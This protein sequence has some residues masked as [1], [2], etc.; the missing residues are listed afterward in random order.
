MRTVKFLRVIVAT[1]PENVK[2]LLN[3]LG[4]GW[5]EG[6][7]MSLSDYIDVVQQA[8]RENK[9]LLMEYS[10]PKTGK[11]TSGRRVEPYE[12]KDGFLF[13]WDIDANSIKKFYEYGISNLEITEEVFLP[14]FPILIY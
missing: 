4:L 7:I 8:A 2:L 14:R 3:A 5:K 11:Y 13:A 10:S 1:I 12:I 9:V 6:N